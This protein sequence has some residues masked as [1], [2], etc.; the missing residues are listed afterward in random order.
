M[1]GGLT[2]VGLAAAGWYLFTQQQQQHQQQQQKK[3]KKET[4]SDTSAAATARTTSAS[5]FAST[6][7]ST[8]APA[9]ADDV[10]DALSSPADEMKQQYDDCI[11]V[12]KKLMMGNSFARAADKYSEAIALA[13]QLPS[14]HKDV[15]TL[16]NNR[17]AMYVRPCLAR[18]GLP[19]VP[20]HPGPATSPPPAGTK[21]QAS[22]T[23][24]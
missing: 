3:T 14:A 9:A 20:S 5:T 12:A 1:L 17:S 11:R 8:S 2:V 13:A 19:C 22:W 24:L 7:A 23:R 10:D 21:R 4:G 6:S 15:M 16:Y 18:L